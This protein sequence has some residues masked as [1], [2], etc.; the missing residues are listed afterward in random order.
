MSFNTLFTHRDLSKCVF[1]Y[2][3]Q[4]LR[5]DDC[6]RQWTKLFLH[7]EHLV[8]LTRMRQL[9]KLFL[10][11]LWGMRKAADNSLHNF[12]H[13]Q[14]ALYGGH[15]EAYRTVTELEHLPPGCKIR[16]F[17]VVSLYPRMS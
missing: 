8:R 1:H 16:Y 9:A 14:H 11:A 7:L 10:N 2:K 17:D 5:A 13:P 15:V 4:M 6:K 12:I 3:K